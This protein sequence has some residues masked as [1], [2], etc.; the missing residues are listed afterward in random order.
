VKISNNLASFLQRVS[1]ACYTE[2]CTSYDRYC[3][4]VCPSQS[5]IMSK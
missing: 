1:I 2:R 5:G 3:L 4:S